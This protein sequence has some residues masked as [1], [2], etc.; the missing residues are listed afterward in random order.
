MYYGDMST[1]AHVL[2]EGSRT[3]LSRKQIDALAKLEHEW[4]EGMGRVI[5]RH[6]PA[7]VVNTIENVMH[8]FICDALGDC[9]CRFNPRDIN[10]NNT[11][12]GTL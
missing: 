9:V 11:N 3:I 10:D 2:E 7:H 5:S 1:N 12:G 4:V 6:M 8:V